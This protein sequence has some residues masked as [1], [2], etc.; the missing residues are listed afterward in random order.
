MIEQKITWSVKLPD[1]K[2]VDL[3]M[4]PPTTTKLEISSSVYSLFPYGEWIF[5]AA[6][7]YLEQGVFSIGTRLEFTF[8][9]AKGDVTYYMSVLSVING[10]GAKATGAGQAYQLVLI[11]SWYFDQSIG[12]NIYMGSVGSITKKL[13]SDE[14]SKSFT[15]VNIT[16]TFDNLKNRYYRTMMTQGKFLES[17][18]K[19]ALGQDKSS[20]FMFGTAEGAFNIVD[21]ASLNT[22]ERYIAID[23]NHPHLPVFKTAI[24]DTVQ[25]KRFLFPSSITINLNKGRNRNLWMLASPALF[26]PRRTDGTV[27]LDRDYPDFVPLTTNQPN[28]FT[29]INSSKQEV[30]VSA[31]LQDDSLRGYEQ[32]LTDKINSYSRDL[33]E[34]HRFDLYCLPNLHTTVGNLC[35]LYI[36]NDQTEELSIFAQDFMVEEVSHI[37]KGITGHTLM[38]L[39]APGLS[40]IDVQKV[41]SLY[42]PQNQSYGQS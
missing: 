14:L 37:F 8:N 16:N 3:S 13:I 41:L 9:T 21:Y 24:E 15:S 26:Y 34:A 1:N 29:Y 30:K 7:D 40:Y 25:S 18:R 22:K 38:T 2:D 4:L 20:V 42:K 39:S 28:P 10:P 33:M 19:Y 35:Y 32:I 17:I 12:S 11:G 27:K 5:M 31:A 23:A 6:G 36:T